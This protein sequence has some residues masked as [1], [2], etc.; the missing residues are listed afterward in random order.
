MT[1]RTR[2]KTGDKVI[3]LR[4]KIKLLVLNSMGKMSVSET[5]GKD[6]RMDVAQMI[7]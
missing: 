4:A 6:D 3:E 2:S 5:I 1:A 7:L